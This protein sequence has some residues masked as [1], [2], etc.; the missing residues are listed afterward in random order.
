MSSRIIT[1]VDASRSRVTI[2][3]TNVTSAQTLSI[4]R[5]CGAWQVDPTDIDTIDS[6]TSGRTCLATPAGRNFL[7]V[8][9][10]SSPP[11]MD[12]IATLAAVIAEQQRLQTVFDAAGA[13]GKKN[14]KP[15]TW[16]QR[17]TAI[18]TNHVIE[19]SAPRSVQK[20]LGLAN[21][22]VLL[23]EYWESVEEIRQSRPVLRKLG[24]GPT[25]ELPVVAEVA[26]SLST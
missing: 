19:A 20:A 12:P 10:P 1:S 17:P 7:E 15:L 6:L 14:T 16:P 5:N 22:L 21:W 11:F 26:Y 23:A 9:V 4:K 24:D 25:R 8:N 13:N 18:R 3:W 2:W